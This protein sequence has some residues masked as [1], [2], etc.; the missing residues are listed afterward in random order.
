MHTHTQTYIH[1]YVYIHTTWYWLRLECAHVV[2]D[3]TVSCD[4][5]QAL[6]WRIDA[7]HLC[8]KH[9]QPSD[10]YISCYAI[11]SNNWLTLLLLDVAHSTITITTT[12]G[13]G[14][15]RHLYHDCL[16]AVPEAAISLKCST[17]T[18]SGSVG[19]TSSE[20]PP[21]KCKTVSLPLYYTSTVTVLSVAQCMCHMLWRNDCAYT[22]RASNV[23]TLLQQAM[24]VFLNLHY[25]HQCVLAAY[26]ELYC[27]C[28]Q[29]VHITRTLT[30]LVL[31][32][33][34]SLLMLVWTTATCDGKTAKSERECL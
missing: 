13:A 1:I 12:A 4:Y 17:S 19:Q 28:I 16:V 7:W 24:Q 2:C 30:L 32:Y 5:W 33:C 9:W 8:D 15:I 14:L 11:H 31:C 23:G 3:S 27:L 6:L 25:L 29:L 34:I 10:T 18:A 20:K 21:P 26:D 22:C